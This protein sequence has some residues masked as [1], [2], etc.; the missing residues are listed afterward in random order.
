MPWQT[1]VGPLVKLVQLVARVVQAVNHLLQYL[2]GGHTAGTQLITAV[3]MKFS[4]VEV[5]VGYIHIVET[6]IRMLQIQ[7]VIF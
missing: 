5:M 2:T 6:M 3:P 7:F 1:N 4:I